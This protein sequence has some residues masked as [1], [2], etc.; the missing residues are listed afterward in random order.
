MKWGLRGDAT[1]LAV[2]SWKKFYSF[3]GMAEMESKISPQVVGA[4]VSV[5]AALGLNSFIAQ[6]GEMAKVASAV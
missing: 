1:F 2:A 6:S 3:M 4:V 5:I